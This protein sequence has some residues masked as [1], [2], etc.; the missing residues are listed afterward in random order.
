MNEIIKEIHGHEAQAP[1]GTERKRDEEQAMTKHNHTNKEEL[2]QSNRLK[3][4]S[5]AG[6]RI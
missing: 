6:T 1:R 3:A 5:E 4:G 2:Q